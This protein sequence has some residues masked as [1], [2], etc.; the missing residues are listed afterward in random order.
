[1]AAK[2]R[3]P[4]DRRSDELDP[5][6]REIKFGERLDSGRGWPWRR[7]DDDRGDG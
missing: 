5:H 3:T 6:T 4:D 7:D 2:A 1:M